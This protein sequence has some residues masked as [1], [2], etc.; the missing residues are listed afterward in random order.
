MQNVIWLISKLLVWFVKMLLKILSHVNANFKL[1]FFYIFF[2]GFLPETF[3]RPFFNIISTKTKNSAFLRFPCSQRKKLLGIIS[4][5]F[6]HFYTFAKKWKLIFLESVFI[7][8]SLSHIKCK[9][10]KPITVC[11]TLKWQINYVFCRVYITVIIFKKYSCV[12]KYLSGF[13]TPSRLYSY[14]KNTH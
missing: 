5:F 10:L 9:T 14:S 12:R 1:S 8:H 4:P 13:S 2:Q 3:L 7:N 11:T 6:K